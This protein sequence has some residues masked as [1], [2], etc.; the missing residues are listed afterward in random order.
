MSSTDAT[1][2]IDLTKR[3][4]PLSLSEIS[5]ALG[6]KSRGNAQKMHKPPLQK[7]ME[8]KP[9]TNRPP[10]HAVAEALEVDLGDD[11]LTT[12]TP[13][14]P[15]EVVLA[16]GKAL[17]YLDQ[18]GQIVPEIAN[19]GRGRWLPVAPTIYPA[20]GERRV[21]INHLAAK[22]STSKES[23][24]MALHRKAFTEPDDTDEI[25]RVV[26]WVQTA[27]EILRT[28]NIEERF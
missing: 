26:W 21:Y 17:G 13:R 15:V 14:F 7:A 20:T 1:E 22:L 5:R 27:N 18:S 12:S 10:L 28:R 23:I 9:P 19:K 11:I 3:T 16:L 8:G 25:G 24:E 6:M 4:E 2:V